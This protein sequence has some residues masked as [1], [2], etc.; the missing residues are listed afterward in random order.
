[1]YD[2]ELD[3]FSLIYFKISDQRVGLHESC[4]SRRVFIDWPAAKI[5]VYGSVKIFHKSGLECNILAI[6]ISS[7]SRD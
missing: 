3:F 6:E 5:T 4:V 1:M 2:S 7:L